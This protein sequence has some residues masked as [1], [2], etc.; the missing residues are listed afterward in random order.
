M[1][2]EDTER[3]FTRPT[4]STT[5]GTLGGAG[6]GPVIVWALNAFA[7]VEVPAEVAASLGAILGNVIGYFFDGGRK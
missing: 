1:S 3:Y 6:I 4:T 5:V 2:E 7:G